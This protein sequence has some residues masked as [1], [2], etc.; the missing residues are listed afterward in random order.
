[1]IYFL[2]I[3][4]STVALARGQAFLDS[5]PENFIEGNSFDECTLRFKPEPPS[6]YYITAIGG[7]R[8]YQGEFQHMAVI[9]WTRSDDQIEW[10]CGGS[11][12]TWQFVLTAAH[13]ATDL[14]NIPPDTVR[15]GDTDLGSTEDDDSAV[16]VP[17]EMVIKHPNYRASRKYYDIALVK[18]IE[19]VWPSNAV[20][21]A[22]IWLEPDAPGVEMEAIGFGAL[23][24]GESNSPTLQKV[25]LTAIASNKCAQRLS[26]N[27]RSSPEGLRRDQFC[28][29][30][31]TMDT[32]AGDSGGPIQTERVDLFGNLFPLIVGVVSFGSP[33]IEGS[34][35]VY[36]RVSSYIDWIEREVNQSLSYDDC[37][38]RFYSNVGDYLGPHYGYGGV[39]AFRG[40]FQHMVAIGWTR[41]GT[42]VQ[43]LCGGSLI[44]NTFVLTAAHC[45]SDAEHIPP[46]TVRIGDTD[47]GSP[48]DDKFAQQISIARFIKHPQ[49]RAS[50]SYFDVALI[51]LQSPATFSD[52]V[53][54]ACLWREDDVPRERMDAIGFGA[55]GFGEALSPTL[56]RVELDAIDLNNCTSRITINRR[57]MPDGFRKDQFCA[58]SSTMDTCE[59][60]SGGPI[61]VK[62][63]DVGG[64][65]YA[66][67]VG[68]VS[69]GTPCVV[70]STGVYK[71][72][73][74][75]FCPGRVRKHISVEFG[76]NY[77]M[78]RFGLLWDDSDTTSLYE[79]GATLIDYQFLITLASCVTS[80]KGYPTYV[81][82]SK[83]ERVAIT[84]VYVSP[85]YR[86]D[87]PAN[88]I[89]LIKI[90]KFVNINKFRPACLWN[91]NIDGEWS[92]DSLFSAY[93][94]LATYEPGSS[95]TNNTI[96]VNGK[97]RSRCDMDK[98]DA[99]GV[100][101]Y[102]NN[103]NLVP[104]V[105]A[106]DYGAP[107][108]NGTLWGLPVF[109]YGLVSTLSKDCGSNLYVTDVTPHIEW[110]ES[111]IIRRRDQYLVFSD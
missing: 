3:V 76:D 51:E 43:Y 27:S 39:R 69:F 79:C 78:N 96:F 56:Q 55:T 19:R 106:M 94:P 87:S 34:T 29:G 109:A 8:A 2:Q 107:V 95:L 85:K 47:L 12:I 77:A 1:M 15:L 86:K 40:E 22:C 81:A 66:L 82:Q 11:L 75:S 54:S 23:G 57:Q 97:A 20:C 110:I 98:A 37:P 32:C 31:P 99:S 84:D 50:K 68:V 48:E 63:V 80:S 100:V 88:N 26:I 13:C 72:I 14:E 41:T 10:L 103:V 111:I 93:G 30:S 35:G 28:A 7:E 74:S 49:Y 83:T 67:I 52:A 45:A 53:C 25:R 9:G 62:K 104:G 70:G 73:R 102:K 42:S 65:E 108:I 24:Y 101:C 60:D 90:A 46:D 91:R 16:E 4:L 58:A 61:G 59:G 33:C 21:T 64:A 17:I 71:C 38:T 44:T 18:L 92:G 105:C 89:A 6:S 36:T 5:P